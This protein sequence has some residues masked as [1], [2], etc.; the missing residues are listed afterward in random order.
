M[1]VKVTKTHIMNG[2]KENAKRC[3]L[4][5]ALREQGFKNVSVADRS[6]QIGGDFYDVRR[7]MRF[8]NRFDEGLPVKP[9]I[10]ELIT[11]RK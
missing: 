7:G 8:I 5:L 1:K 6:V 4:A 2:K 11:P 9:T 3:P 10:I